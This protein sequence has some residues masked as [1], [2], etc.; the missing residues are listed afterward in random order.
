LERLIKQRAASARKKAEQ[1]LLD[2]AACFDIYCSEKHEG[3]KALYID[4]WG[5]VIDPQHKLCPECQ[6][7]L[8][9]TMNRYLRCPH[10]PKP[11]CKTCDNH[12]FAPAYRLRFQEVI[13]FVESIH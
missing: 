5:V 6:E 1:E 12:C 11:D 7:L 2:L 10:S 13:R 4:D 9:Y 8:H 3:L